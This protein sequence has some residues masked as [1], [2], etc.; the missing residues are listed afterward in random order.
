MTSSFATPNSLPEVFVT[1]NAGASFVPQVF[2]L[3]ICEAF[4]LL[5]VFPFFKK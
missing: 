3:D 4:S 5:L 2:F 1:D